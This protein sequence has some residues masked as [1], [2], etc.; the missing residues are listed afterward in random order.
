[1]TKIFVLGSHRTGTKSLAGFF[2]KNFDDMTSYHQYDTLRLVN[3]TS[4]M[5]LSKAL[6]KVLFHAFLKRFWINKIESHNNRFYVESNGFNYMAA[7]YA[8]Q[9]F[10]DVKIIHAIRDPRTFVTSYYNWVE[11]RDKSKFAKNFVPYW[12]LSP[13]KLGLLSKKEWEAM[14]TFERYCW[15]WNFKNQKIEELYS[16]DAENYFLLKFEDLIDEKK[17]ELLLPDLLNFLKLPYSPNLLR[18]FDKKQNQSQAKLIGHWSTWDQDKCQKINK[19]CASLM[20]K[21]NYGVEEKWTNMLNF[22]KP[23]S[24]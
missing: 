16:K 10:D 24:I 6:P 12:N 23:T 19:H 20:A 18:Y 2:D 17:R 22:A 1:M 9:Y 8:K 7:D 15:N 5:Y 3:V 4:N 11:G 21:Y 14:D 13:H